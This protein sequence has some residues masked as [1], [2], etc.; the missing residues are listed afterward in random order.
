MEKP[1][2]DLFRLQGE[3]S[4]KWTVRNPGRLPGRRQT[5][6]PRATK[7][8]DVSEMERRERMGALEGTSLPTFLPGGLLLRHLSVH[9]ADHPVLPWSYAAWGQGGH[10]LLHHTQ[11]PQAVRL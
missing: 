3:A 5:G 2:A 9:H 11:L 10:P 8:M 1:G 7:D 6:R 4:E